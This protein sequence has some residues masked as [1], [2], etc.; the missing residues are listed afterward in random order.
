MEKIRRWLKDEKGFTLIEMALVLII[1]GIILGAIVKGK[2][3][4]KTAQQKKVY[5]SYINAWNLAYMTHYD[6][7][8]NSFTLDDTTAQVAA[9]AL[10]AG[11]T[12]PPATYEYQDSAG[13]NRT[14]TITFSSDATNNYN[15]MH[16]WDI[17]SELGLAMDKIVDGVESATA[18]DFLAASVTNTV[19]P[20][21]VW[22]NTGTD[23]RDARWKLQF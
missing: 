1:I 19:S 10:K 22:S 3:I 6:R 7:T 8:G 2:D 16:I 15:Y 11:L 21:V 9:Q 23:L 14:M 4:M 18:G 20:V 13:T 12:P 5:T 17:P